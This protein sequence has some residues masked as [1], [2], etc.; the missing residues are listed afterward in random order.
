MLTNRENIRGG[1]LRI[2]WMNKLAV[3]HFKCHEAA[4]LVTTRLRDTT[5]N[6]CFLCPSI[7]SVVPLFEP[8]DKEKSTGAN[9]LE[10][11]S[12]ER[13][14]SWLVALTSI[15][16]ITH[17]FHSSAKSDEHIW[18]FGDRGGI[19][20]VLSSPTREPTGLSWPDSTRAAPGIAHV[21]SSV[22]VCVATAKRLYQKE[23]AYS[24]LNVVSESNMSDL[25]LVRTPGNASEVMLLVTNQGIKHRD[26]G[27][28]PFLYGGALYIQRFGNDQ[29]TDSI[30]IPLLTDTVC[31]PGFPIGDIRR[32]QSG[33]ALAIFPHIDGKSLWLIVPMVYP[34]EIRTYLID[35][36]GRI[37]QVATVKHDFVRA[38]SEDALISGFLEWTNIG[39]IKV[40]PS[41]RTV[42]LT[43]GVRGRILLYDFNSAD[44][45]LSNCRVLSTDSDHYDGNIGLRPFINGVVI[46]YG[47]EYSPD[48]RHLYVSR[49]T[50]EGMQ[51][52]SLAQSTYRPFTDSTQ[53][54]LIQFDITSNSSQAIRDSR[55]TIVPLSKDNR[56]MGLQLG[57]DGRIYVA[58][59][60]HQFVSRIN[61]PNAAGLACGFE[62][63]AMKLL[64]S[65]ACGFGFPF[66]MA[67]TLGPQLRA[68]SQDVCVGDTA[69]IPLAG[70]FITDSVVWDFGDTL[71][72]TNVGYGRTGSH[73]YSAPGAY[74]V[75]A[76]MYV[77]SQPEKP[78]TAWVYV[79]PNPVAVASTTRDSICPGD[80]VELVGSG[81]TS[82]KWY[83]GDSLLGTG[84]RIIFRPDTTTTL[85][86]IVESAFGCLDTT[87]LTVR[88]KPA[89]LISMISDTSVCV[90]SIVTIKASVS[91]ALSY[92]WSSAPV[93][94]TLRSNGT[95]A[96]FKAGSNAS[97]TIKATAA[98]GCTSSKTII[99]TVLPLPTVVARGD[100]T[101]CRPSLV[102][103]SASGAQTYTWLEEA[104]GSVGIGSSLTVTPQQTTKYVV[105]GV[106]SNGCSNT[107]T[108]VVTLRR[109]IDLT[110]AGDNI[111]CDGQPITLV[112]T[113]PAGVNESDILWLDE[114]G[115]TFA[116][117]KSVTVLP[118][119]RT[120]YRATLPGA[121]ECTD[122][123][124]HEIKVGTRPQFTITPS[125]TVVCVGDTVV[126][127]SSGGIVMNLVAQPGVQ[128]YSITESDSIGCSNTATATLRGIAPSTISAALPDT[129]V[130]ISNGTTTLHVN[131][132]SPQQF[133]GTTLGQVV[134]RVTHQTRSI[135]IDRFVDA[136]TGAT[137]TPSMQSNVADRSQFE[138]TVPTTTLTSTIEPLLN[139]EGLPLVDDDSTS[140]VDV[141][142]L[143]IAGLGACTDSSS[144][145]GLLTITGC[146]R[147]YMSGLRVGS[148][149]SVNAYPNPTS[150]NL[151]VA[152][153]VGTI[154]TITIDLIDALGLRVMSSTA[155]RTST[156]RSIDTQTIDMQNIPAGTYRVVVST[157]VEVRTVGVVKR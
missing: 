4:L 137:L 139:I 134:L 72:P 136:R 80:T 91:G 157:P 113:A 152:V 26:T 52:F 67:S 90:G 125:D 42:A 143:S 45:V 99:V 126:A 63:V 16:M 8:D 151:T 141:Q 153:D 109:D 155:T 100:T 78:V 25:L 79:H 124:V 147:G 145:G 37:G 65:T 38:W 58:Q 101:I 3:L 110:V 69:H 138:V 44:G 93:D 49:A 130:D 105:V 85:T 86:M 87:S 29:T 13:L 33:S 97:Y 7:N 48:E 116:T 106:D 22:P 6:S 102:N 117:G 149:L 46:P 18:Y 135:K 19:K 76:T 61:N 123:V 32:G 81:G 128:Q 77:G 62:R 73:F 84:K 35:Q 1:T 142:I 75:T 11:T 119:R 107:D 64:D 121:G 108:V 148:A 132:I 15:L 14:S 71:S 156:S 30:Q 2:R 98:N 129:T 146:G 115:A 144:K 17:P 51:L 118:T 50:C 53:G 31:S 112:C 74:F 127:K 59:R 150:D 95:S 60:G 5:I 57:P 140:T 88:V 104:G 82:I 40:A 9:L 103:L 154:G 94:P 21:N 43:T 114:A 83:D 66:V 131:I 120:V 122:T 111:S 24:E 12:R 55:T 10:S 133:V 68:V 96:T 28:V 41:G 36:N 56:F 54:E 47:I 89:A 20:F 70:A 39:E 92:V 23:W 27:S 34:S